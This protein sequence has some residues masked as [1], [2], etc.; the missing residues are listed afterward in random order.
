MSAKSHLAIEGRDVAV[1]SLD[2]IFYPKT[3]FLK[4][5]V[6]DYYQQIAPVL[7]PHLKGR[8]VTLKRYPDGV[9]GNFFYEKQCPS[10][11]PPWIKTNKVKRSDGTDID[12][13]RLDDLPSL[14]WAANIANLEIHPFQHRAAA[15]TRPTA[16]VF[17][18]DPGPPADILQCAQVAIWI[19]DLL[20]RLGLASFV[21][22]SGSKGLQLVVP[23]NTRTSYARTKPLAKGIA[24]AL[25]TQFPDSVTD[26]M[27]IAV[28]RGRVFIDW[29]QNDDHKTT[30][31]VYSLRA[32]EVP[33]VSTPLTWEELESALRKKS[34]QRL[35]FLTK[36]VLKRVSRDGDLFAPVLTLK[37]NLPAGVIELG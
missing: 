4:A 20:Q 8:S 9:E 1:S 17:D 28:R 6:L 12:Y 24:A 13:C 16:L 7:L 34:A 30:V 29:S 33:S 5:N 22:T 37:Q 18:L 15:P 21:K 25:A 31:S 23:L 14:I 10:H 27:K 36:E 11:A 32:R 3:G 35:V 19:R 26:D 2:K